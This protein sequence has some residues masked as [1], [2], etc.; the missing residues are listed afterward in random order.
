MKDAP[1]ALLGTGIMGE[2]M[3]RRMLTAGLDVRVWNRTASKAEPLSEAGA[4]VASTPAEAVAGAGIVVTMLADEAATLDVMEGEAL[5]AMESG[6]VWLQMGTIGVDGARRAADLAAKHG[7][8]LVDAPVLGT[9]QPAEQ[10]QLL[11]LASGNDSAIDRCQPIF[12]AVARQTL[13]LGPAG[14]GSRM[15]LVING[16]LLGLLGSLADTLALAETLGIGGARFLEAIEGG[17]LG[18]PYAAMVGAKMLA[19]DYPASFPLELAAKDARLIEE[20]AREAGLEP[21]VVPAVAGLLRRAMEAGLG[22][23]DMSAVYEAARRS[24]SDPAEG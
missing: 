18:V 4:T 16:W 12:E 21:T 23:H 2:A 17:P 5:P 14:T 8:E 19:G 10:G 7:V 1:V 3:A 9:R 6:A 13:R 22:D 20:A 24:T 11:V 15:K